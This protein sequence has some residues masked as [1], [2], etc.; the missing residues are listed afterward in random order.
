MQLEQL[1]IKTLSFS[2]EESKF[3]LLHIKEIK[4]KVNPCEIRVRL[5][6]Q[7]SNGTLTSF[8]S[9]SN[10]YQPSKDEEIKHPIFCTVHYSRDVCLI[11]TEKEIKSAEQLL[12]DF[13]ATKV[14]SPNL[15]K[16]SVCFLL[17]TYLRG[18]IYE[19]Q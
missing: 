7:N 9:N 16:V 15:S 6:N 2:K 14:D 10:K 12:W 4:V 5:T 13:F 18:D 1:Q 11:G 8:N 19:I 3:V 17:P